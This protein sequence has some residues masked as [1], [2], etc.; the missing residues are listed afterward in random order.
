MII[1]IR[2]TNGSG[3]STIVRSILKKGN[4][5][6]LYGMLGPKLPEAERLQLPRA[7]VPTYVLGPY[8]AAGFG[9]CDLIST[10]V[11]RPQ[12]DSLLPNTTNDSVEGLI[13]RYAPKG[14][15]LFE[16]VVVSYMYGQ[17]GLL[18]EK[19]GKDSVFLFLD[20]PLEECIR[21]VEDRRGERRDPRLIRNVTRK[22]EFGERLRKR[23]TLE[24][25]VR[26]LYLD[27]E[28]AGREVVRLLKQDQWTDPEKE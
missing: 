3:K 17:V 6:P 26:V 14:H 13:A 2:G 1:S 20:T 23:L 22:Y 21:R 9:G 12:T 25:K 24:G 28:A 15:V 5:Y 18:M 19:W 7:K 8:P 11:S 16:G 10:I 4:V 27:T